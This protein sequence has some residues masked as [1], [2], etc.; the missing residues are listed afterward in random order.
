MIKA[1]K[2]PQKKIQATE[3]KI[4]PL[5]IKLFPYVLILILGLI[6]YSNSFNC[7]FTFDDG[8]IIL[9]NKAI[10]HIGNPGAIWDFYKTRFVGL[11][12]FA[13]NYHFNGLKVFGYHAVN[14]AIHIINAFLVMWLALLFFSSPAMRSE[15]ISRHSRLLSLACALVFV[16]HPIQTQGVTYIVQRLASLATLF[17]LFS[18]CCY[19]KAR[20]SDKRS[21]SVLFFLLAAASALF[22]MFTKEIV[23][24]L[25]FALILFE[26]A[27][28]TKGSLKDFFS[29][30]ERYLY[31]LIPLILLLIV[32][33]LYS[34]KTGVIF[35]PVGSHRYQDPELT[36][37]IY[38]MTQFKVIVRYIGLLAVPVHQ[39]LLHD[40]AASKG[41]FNPATILGFLFLSS[42]VVLAIWL[43]P[44]KRAVSAG[45]LWFFI[46]LSVESS[47]IPIPST[48]FEHRLYLPMFGFSLF[49]VSIMYYLVWEKFSQTAAITVFLAIVLAYS[50][51][52]FERNKVWK[53]RLT[54]WTDVVRKS[55]NLARPHYN[56]GCALLEKK[57]AENAKNEFFKTLEIN[58]Y[59]TPAYVKLGTMAS[60]SGDYAAA[61]KYSSDAMLRD[62]YS[63]DVYNNLG[64]AYLLSGRYEEAAGVLQKALVYFPDN[65]EVHNNLGSAYLFLENYQAAREEL[66]KSLA[67]DPVNFKA[68]MNLGTVSLM[69]DDYDETISIFSKALTLH[70]ENINAQFQIGMALANRGMVD[71][72]TMYLDNVVKT[73]PSFAQAHYLLGVILRHKGVERQASAHLEKAVELRPEYKQ[74]PV[75]LKEALDYLKSERTLKAKKTE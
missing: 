62:P 4:H 57:Y 58:P 52:T 25:P 15:P 48:M 35:H 36:S 11:Y 38:L 56:L 69:L 22:G 10:R 46:T 51:M 1:G 64:S 45:I 71:R 5:I 6:V 55:P 41:F 29:H 63:V 30:R 37:T 42:I 34:F 43:F 9:N 66:K 20:L 44:R 59:Y 28:F 21:R 24:T 68:L 16:S 53:D 61:I 13:L 74:A 60:M 47:I 54:L 19:M 3:R 33:A 27:A 70:P 72:A 39:N 23:F 2:K 40:V 17:Y 12:T 31:F 65:V 73:A 67:V 18:V 49:F 14:I 32:P 26:L 7:D 50:V 8:N 75:E